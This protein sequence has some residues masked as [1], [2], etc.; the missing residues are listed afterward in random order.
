MG[1][2]PGAR[3]S[4]R[5]GVDSM[6]DVG[7]RRPARGFTLIE[8]MIVIVVIG[9]LVGFVLTAATGGIRRAEQRATESLIAKLDSGLTDRLDALL[10]TRAAATNAHLA[11][12]TLYSTG[13]AGTPLLTSGVD[14]MAGTARAQVLAQFDM[15]KAEMADAW[16]MPG[17]GDADYNANYPINFGAHSFPTTN[18]SSTYTYGGSWN[19]VLPLGAFAPPPSQTFPLPG[20]GMNGAAYTVAAGFY[21]NAGYQPVGYDGIDN[22]GDGLIDDSSDGTTLSLNANLSN[23]KHGTARAEMLY[24]ILVEGQGPFGSVFSADD[25]TTKEVRDTDGDGLPEFVDAWGQPLQFFRW[26]IYYG[27]HFDTTQ[28]LWIYNSDLQKGLGGYSAFEARQQ[29]SLDPNQQLMAPSWWYPGAN[30]NSG[31]SWAPASSSP[32]SGAAVFFQYYFHSLTDPLAGSRDAYTTTNITTSTN[33]PWD[34]G[35]TNYTTRRAYSSKFLILSG[36]PDLEPGVFLYPDSATLSVSALMNEGNAWPNIY[37][38]TGSTPVINALADP[39]APNDDITNHN[40]Q[41]AGGS[42]Q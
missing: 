26:P 9:I 20:T 40:L 33:L 28:N 39:E 27:A 25:F 21:K 4:A 24:A 13:S 10:T 7:S 35:S 22:D 32:L 23:H 37:D 1:L 17:S 6:R 8:L 12:A 31:P 36:G 30:S 18:V 38:P 3:T 11:L 41:A 19:F 15:V 2:G 16:Y 34:R 42:I 29:N 14:P 5:E